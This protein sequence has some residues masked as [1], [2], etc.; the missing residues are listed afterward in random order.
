MVLWCLQV[1]KS[2]VSAE[3][4]GSKRVFRVKEEPVSNAIAQFSIDMS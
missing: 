3:M 1:I 4:C 2:S